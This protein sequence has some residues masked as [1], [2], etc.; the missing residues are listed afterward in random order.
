M[1][2]LAGLTLRVKEHKASVSCMFFFIFFIFLGKSWLSYLPLTLYVHFCDRGV[3]VS[4]VID[5]HALVHS[6]VCSAYLIYCQ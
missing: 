5:R 3:T 1:P 6:S 4:Q 2:G